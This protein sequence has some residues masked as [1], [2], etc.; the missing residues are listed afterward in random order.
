MRI[1]V[2][3]DEQKVASALRE[4]LEAD[5][6]SVR[7]AHTG[8]EGFYLVQ[9]LRIGDRVPVATGS[10]TAGVGATTTAVNAL[11]NTQF[12][13]LDV[14]V[15]V[16][17]TPRIHPNHEIS[18]KVNIVVSSVTGWPGSLFNMSANCSAIARK[19]A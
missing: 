6:Y 19:D 11:V 9:A 4:G 3:E 18:M 15:Q 8:E 12:Q 14:G 17:V 1:L 7:V 2:V 10:F 13:Y 5:D 16:D